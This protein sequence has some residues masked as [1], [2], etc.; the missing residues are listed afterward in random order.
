MSQ[1]ATADDE[2]WRMFLLSENSVV[3][4]EI[5]FL[6]KSL[7]IRDLDVEERVADS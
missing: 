3:R 6:Q 5:V 1:G 4:L 7:A 2:H